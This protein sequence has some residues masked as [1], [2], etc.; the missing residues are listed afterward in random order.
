[1][2]GRDDR[3]SGSDGPPQSMDGVIL[4]FLFPRINPCWDQIDGTV[5]TSPDDERKRYTA[6]PRW[7]DH[8]CA[9][10]VVIMC[11]IQTN[12]GRR[13]A[14]YHLNLSQLGPA[15]FLLKRIVMQPWGQ[16]TQE[17]RDAL[18][19]ELLD[20]LSLMDPLT[21]PHGPSLDVVEVFRQCLLNFPQV[22]WME[23]P[24]TL[25]CCQTKF[26]FGKHACRNSNMVMTSNDPPRS[27]ESFLRQRYST[28]K[29]LPKD[30]VSACR[31]GKRCTLD[32]VELTVVMGA[33]PPVLSVCLPHAITH[34]ASRDTWKLD[35]TISFEYFRSDGHFRVHYEPVGCIGMVDRNHYTLRWRHPRDKRS[36]RTQVWFCDTKVQADRLTYRKDW[37]DGLPNQLSSD[38]KENGPRLMLYELIQEDVLEAYPLSDYGERPRFSSFPSP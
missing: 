14:D 6:Y 1:M 30:E 36:P 12:I 20:L 25:R 18:R 13:Q 31:R 32:C 27:V 34:Q 24:K 29:T 2:R 15:Q 11:A 19:D 37:W 22:T 8:S 7:K 23:L 28:T 26:S 16:I 38:E 9:V 35:E 5:Q 33:L 17:T 10:D 3:T 4:T 21:F